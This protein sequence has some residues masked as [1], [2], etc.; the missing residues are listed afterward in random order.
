M[1]V[2]GCRK[3][4]SGGTASWEGADRA[5]DGGSGTEGTTVKKDNGDGWS[6]SLLHFSLSPSARSLQ[7]RSTREGK[8][9]VDYAV[10]KAIH[11]CCRRAV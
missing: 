11:Q 7:R 10:E 2:G 6:P 5:G 3:E 9:V 8:Q 4:T 1:G